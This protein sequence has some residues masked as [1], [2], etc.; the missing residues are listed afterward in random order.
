MAHP[1]HRKS[2][3]KTGMH[4]SH[5]H[6]SKPTLARCPNCGEF[7]QPHVMCSSCGY[8]KDREVID[9]AQ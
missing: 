3:S 5:H 4:R 6:L 1:K 7:C 8:Y 9:M 2:K